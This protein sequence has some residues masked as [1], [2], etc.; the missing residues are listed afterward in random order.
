LIRLEPRFAELA[1]TTNFSFLRGASHPEE[2]VARAAELGLAGIGIADRNSL[3]GVVRAHTFARDNVEAMAA[4]RVVPGARL[5]FIDGCPDI[6]VYP[7]NRAGY[8]RLC[9]ILTE[10]NLRAPKGECWLI[11]KDL[12]DRG[13][14]LQIVA[15]PPSPEGDG[16]SAPLPQKDK[17]KL[18]YKEMDEGSALPRLREAFGKRLWIGAS[19]VYGEDMRGGLARCVALARSVGAPLMATNDVLMHTPERRTLADVLTCIR[20]KTTLEAAGRL[21]QANAE[22]HLKAPREMARLFAE[23]P[24]AIAETIRFLDGLAFRLDELRHCYPEELREG[25]ATPQEALEAFAWEGAKTRYP[26]GVPERTREALR[27]ELALIASLDYAPYFLTVHDIVRFARSKGILCQGRG[28]AANSAVCYCLRITEVNPANFDLLFERFISPERNEPPDIDVDFEHERR[29]EVIQYIY[30]HYGRERASL[31][32]AVITYRTRSAIR[33]TAKVF[34]LSDDVVAALNGTA[35]GQE[36]APIGEDRVR[37]IGLNPADPTLNLALEMAKA[38]IGFPRHLTQHSGGFVITRD[39]LD[40]VVPVMN[41]AMK[42]RTMVEWDKDDL[43]A[44][45]LLKV[46]V[47]ALGMLTALSKGFKLLDKHCGEQLTLANIPSEEACVYAMIQRADTIGVFQI[48][49]RAQMSMLPRLKPANFYDLV[50]E[51]AIVRPGPIQGDMVHPYL[52]RRQGVEDVSYPSP[53]LEAVLS[54]TLGVPLFQEQAMKIAIAAAGFTPSEAD[55]LRRAMATFRRSGTIQTL[56]EKM[57]EGMV[58]NGY[59][60]EFAE[61]CFHQ[62]E[63]FGEYGFPESHAASF[64]LL[65]YASCWMKCRYPDVFVAAMLN[66]QPLGFYAPAQLVRDAREH[67][68][69]V[70]EVDVNLSDWDCTLEASPPSPSGRGVGGEGEGEGEGKPSSG[71]SRHLLPEGEGIHPRHA[72]MAPHMRTTHAVRLGFRQ[73]IGVKEKDMLR[74]VER[75]GEAYDS[76][77]DLWLRSGLSSTVLERLA[78]ADAFRSL[79]LDRRQ[80]LWAVRGLDRV[81]DQDDLPLFASRPGRETEP[82]ARLPPMPLGAHVVE[83]Y[84]RLSLSLKAHPASFMR[85]RL[86]ARGI[87]RSEALR[88]VKNGERVTVAG[89]VLVR[90]RPGTAAGVIFMTLEDETGVANIIVW[91]KIFERLRAIVLGAR[92]VAVTGKLQSEQGVI[93]IVAERMN[94]LTPMLG[95]LSEAGP[96]IGALARA[97]EAHRTEPTETRKRQGNRFAQPPR[98]DD[99]R[100]KPPSPPMETVVVAEAMP[101][102]RNFR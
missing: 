59:P 67:G 5:V 6:L 36:T 84:R 81:G 37:A 38:L 54:K 41:T 73:I 4:T 43:D 40:E 49:S 51:V 58:V 90:Q 9:R 12:L 61:R 47:L 69:E 19:L 50:I 85:A 13:E 82:D 88:S 63:G 80:A 23:A 10:G 31:A 55:Q 16:K 45:G 33:E 68:V 34:S 99:P 48:E 100:A 11:L 71:A 77:R 65:V 32:A 30:E 62:I 91:P 35:W 24:E 102:G 14:G 15:M 2:M 83:D 42:E 93:H 60:R 56:Q 18:G 7:K 86:S 57:I 29:E 92:F 22:R 39:R 20:K 76:V 95:L 64:A 26:D 3:A 94:D 53:E 46:D 79:G 89:L 74:L 78:D 17:E 1:T 28:S 21:T 101:A 75:R 98:L 44:L 70:R 96:T 52:R 8:G 25:H 27:Y 72:E 97:D 87:L 66:A